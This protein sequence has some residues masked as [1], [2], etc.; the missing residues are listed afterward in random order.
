MAIDIDRLTRNELVD[1]NRRIVERLKFMDALDAHREIM[2]LSVGARVRFE[3]PG[4]GE[5]QGVLVKYN[6]KTVTVIVGSEH[7]NIS[8]HLLRTAEKEAEVIDVVPDRGDG[9]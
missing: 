2:K 4:R 7:W 9:R 6:R 8:P 1:L 5:L 3:A